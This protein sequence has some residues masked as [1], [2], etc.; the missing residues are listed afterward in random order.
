MNSK[1]HYTMPKGKDIP[2]LLLGILGIG[3]S[4]PVIA[5]SK[6]P[7]PTLVFWR[8]LGGTFLLLPFALR[9]REWKTKEHRKAITWSM[10]AGVWLGLHFLA[11]F[12]AMRYTTEI[13]RAH[14]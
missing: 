3:T 11:F 10:L 9:N 4:G 1:H 13:G 8:N 14:V 7:I 5:D 6:M 12:A 2:L